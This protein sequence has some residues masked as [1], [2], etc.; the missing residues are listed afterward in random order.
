MRNGI[1]KQDRIFN[2][3]S[4]PFIGAKSDHDPQSRW[5]AFVSRLAEGVSESRELR[6]RLRLDGKR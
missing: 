1:P 5:I 6:L 4:N 3:D 2:L